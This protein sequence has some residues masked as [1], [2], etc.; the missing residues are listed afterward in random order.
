MVF[1]KSL[2]LFL[3]IIIIYIE[4][5]IMKNFS[6]YFYIFFS[7]NFY[8]EINES[9]EYDSKI[10]KILRIYRILHVKYH[11]IFPTSNF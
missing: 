8:T 2:E 10:E 3:F 4:N 7:F 1:R 9:D 5:V 11:F 6:I